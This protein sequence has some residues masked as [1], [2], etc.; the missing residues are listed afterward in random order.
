MRHT[1]HFGDWYETELFNV[2]NWTLPL[3]RCDICNHYLSGALK[4]SSLSKTSCLCINTVNNVLWNPT[5]RRH[6]CT[7]QSVG[8]LIS[9][10]ALDA[11]VSQ[12]KKDGVAYCWNE[13]FIGKTKMTM[14]ST[15]KAESKAFIFLQHIYTV[16]NTHVLQQ[17]QIS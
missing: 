15:V 8:S 6:S 7:Q 9:F 4:E 13:L 11:F 17:I 3:E 5:S 16:D 1:I 10:L 2:K 14:I 12:L